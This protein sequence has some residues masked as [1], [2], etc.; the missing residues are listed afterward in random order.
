M[1][2]AGSLSFLRT[3]WYDGAR[4]GIATSDHLRI[5][6][7]PYVKVRLGRLNT[8]GQ[9]KGVDGLIYRDITTL[10]RAGAIERAYLFTGDEDMRENVSAAQDLGLQ[11]VLLTF[12]PTKQTGRSA[13]LVREVDEVI[14][15]D[16]AF[17]APHFTKRVTVV[18]PSAPPEPAAIDAAAAEFANKWASGSTREEMRELLARAPWMPKDLYVQLLLA[19][20]ASLGSLK[21]SPEAKRDLRKAFWAVLGKDEQDEEQSEE[22]AATSEE[23]GTL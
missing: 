16:P 8:R 15:L 22:T 18:A 1:A 3:Y 19:A 13:A 4:D 10:A 12:Q 5:G 7:L 17:W 21:E 23:T 2:H 14:V 11:V 6:D 20:E 9:Q